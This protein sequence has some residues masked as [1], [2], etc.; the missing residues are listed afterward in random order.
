MKD[1]LL[2]KDMSSS[3]TYIFVNVKPVGQKTGRRIT[4]LCYQNFTCEV[5]EVS[6]LQVCSKGVST[7]RQADC[8]AHY[9][10]ISKKSRLF[11]PPVFYLPVGIITPSTLWLILQKAKRSANLS[12]SPSS[13][14][15]FD[16]KDS[17]SYP[18][19]SRRLPLCV[20]YAEVIPTSQMVPVTQKLWCVP[21]HYTT[22][23]KRN[24]MNLWQGLLF[25]PL[26]IR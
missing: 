19:E 9:Q 20:R 26:I 17:L 8:M 24:T 3:F 5:C 2:V 21:T 4:K 7:H 15:C 22:C 23:R 10:L 6:V 1:A 18:S 25:P 12:L 16:N 13:F 14:L 11:L